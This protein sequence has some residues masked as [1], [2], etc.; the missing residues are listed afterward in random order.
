MNILDIACQTYRVP[1][2]HRF[3]TAHGT[4][5]VRE[6]AILTLTTTQTVIGVG[7]IAPFPG[8]SKETLTEALHALNTF[9]PR[10]H[11]LTLE[12]ALT[13]LER[14][15]ETLPP[16]TLCGIEMAL[17]DALERTFVENRFI[18]SSSRKN[19]QSIAVNAVIGA[20]TTSDAIHAA[21]QVKDNGFSCVKL[22][23]GVCDSVSQ[24]IARIA[25]VRDALGSDIALR[26]D[27]NEGWT[28]EEAHTVLLECAP[29]NI[30]YI[31]Q[32]LPAHH[33]EGMRRLRKMVPM[34]VAADE[35]VRDIQSARLLIEREAA[36]VLILKPQLVGGLRACRQIVEETAR[37]GITCVLTTTIESGVSVA[38]TLKLASTLPEITLACGLGTLP[39]LVDD[40]ICEHLSI[41]N[42]SMNVLDGPGWGVTLDEGA[43]HKYS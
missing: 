9:I 6:G 33:I 16:S 1:F 35:A 14:E 25:A 12:N 36:D 4:L 13:V 37:R 41:K 19:T 2:G 15:R 21:V 8:M 22:K 30:Q 20:R 40:L 42:G 18:D 29:F 7:E 3:S 11:N 17:L 27:A 32:P 26:L 39:L 24:E 38:A 31:E 43:M 10:L 34:A 5:A 23:V 28:F